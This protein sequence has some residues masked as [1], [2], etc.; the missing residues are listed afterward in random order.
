MARRARMRVRNVNGASVWSGRGMSRWVR[1]IPPSDLPRRTYF[2]VDLTFR[3]PLSPSFLL[4]QHSRVLDSCSARP[5]PS[6]N[7]LPLAR[8]FNLFQRIEPSSLATPQSTFHTPSQ[9]K[10]SAHTTQMLSQYVDAI[11]ISSWRFKSKRNKPSH[12]WN[13]HGH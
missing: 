10:T 4:H 9:A 8:S 6:I 13:Q 3:L 12:E 2:I 7:Q 5:S 1:L 11:H